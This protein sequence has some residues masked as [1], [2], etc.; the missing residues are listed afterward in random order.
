MQH[1]NRS[2]VL[3]GTTA[4]MLT[5]ATLAHGATATLAEGILDGA[6]RGALIGGGVGL[7][8]GIIV[9]LTKKKPKAGDDQQPGQRNDPQDDQLD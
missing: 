5:M 9:A 6:L 2:I 7:V 3:L 1:L 4:L 8:I